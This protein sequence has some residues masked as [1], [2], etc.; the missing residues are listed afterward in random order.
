RTR[1]FIIGVIAAM[2]AGAA[3]VPLD[4]EYPE[5]R[6]Q[7][8]MADSAADILL[9]VDEY[10]KLSRFFT[11]QTINLDTVTASGFPLP[12]KSW[13][14]DKAKGED[15][16]YMIYTSGSTGKP[17]GVMISHSNLSNL[18]YNESLARKLNE[19]T[20]CAQY[21]SFCFDASVLGI[22][23]TLANGACL[24]LFAEDVRKDAIQVCEILKAEAINVVLIPT[25]M[26][27]IIIDNLTDGGSLTH[28]IVGGEK[29]KHY[30]D[31]PYTVVNA[32][33]PTESTV[34]STIFNVDHEYHNIPIGKSLINVFSYI[35]DEQMNQ[36][37][38]GMPGELCHAGRQISRGYHNLP[39][40]T[41]AAFVNN[42]FTNG[43]QD[44]V[45]YRT[46]DMVRRRGDGLIEYIGRIDS[47]VK[48]RGYR[49]ELSEIEGAMSAHPGIKETAVTVLE[50]AGNQYIVA[51]YTRPEGQIDPK[52]WHHLL[53]SQL[54]EYMIPSFYVHL[55]AMPVTPGGKVDKKALPQPETG[56]KIADYLAPETA[57][58]KQLVEI[59]SATLGLETVSVLDDFFAIGGTSISATKVAMKCLSQQIPLAYADLFEYKTVQ[60]LAA[61]IEK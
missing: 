53:L 47:Q 8:M 9:Y 2:K 11:N 59:F 16:A 28:F 29:L 30:Y 55:A 27:E 43:D 4:P 14:A 54:P 1:E 22:F 31:R 7:Y 5:D 39:D 13:A 61:L 19:N 40:K 36:V 23:P 33:G 12:D 3:Y 42:P 32:Y 35:V 15:L 56:I 58:E 46:G 24:Y 44:R 34:V 6:L 48:I 51:Y 50:Q 41:A 18:I 20:K 52:V 60:Q 45:L 38:V 57:L 25:Q 17:K 10:Q 37:P 26:G 49:I 21:S